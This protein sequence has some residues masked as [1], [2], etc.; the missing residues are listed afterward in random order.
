MGS[1]TLRQ[2]G[3][4]AAYLSIAMATTAAAADL[5]GLGAGLAVPVMALLALAGL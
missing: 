4:K 2:L 5:L 3:G 1:A